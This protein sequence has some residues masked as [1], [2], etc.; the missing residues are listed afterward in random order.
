[1]A[2]GTTTWTREE[3]L[4]YLVRLSHDAIKNYFAEHPCNTW[5]GGCGGDWPCNHREGLLRRTA[6]IID[7]S[8]VFQLKAGKTR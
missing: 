3:Q 7:K 1:M 2:D 5:T 8:R 4:E 6:Q